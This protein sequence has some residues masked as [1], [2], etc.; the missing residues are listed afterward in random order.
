MN[1][2]AVSNVVN[3]RA[4][5]TASGGRGRVGREVRPGTLSSLMTRTETICARQE[6]STVD[7]YVPVPLSIVSFLRDSSLLERGSR[8]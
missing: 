2:L 7:G 6:E 5:Q 3:Q 4:V 8:L 1:M